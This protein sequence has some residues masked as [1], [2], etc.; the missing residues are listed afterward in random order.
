MVIYNASYNKTD[1]EFNGTNLYRPGLTP[2]AS[3]AGIEAD[4]V[5]YHDSTVVDLPNNTVVAHWHFGLPPL[6]YKI[7][8]KLWYVNETNGH[9][10]YA[11]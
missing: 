3:Y 8:P 6:G 11:Y 1:I 10:H 5:Y 4:I 2:K 7:Y 9:V